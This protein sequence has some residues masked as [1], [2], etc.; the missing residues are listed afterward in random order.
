MN[1]NIDNEINRYYRKWL[2]I[3]INGNILHLRLPKNVL[4]YNIKTATEIHAQ[5]KLSVLII[6]TTSRNEETRNLHKVTNN[7]NVTYDY[8]LESTTATEKHQT[9]QISSKT[10]S[11]QT[12]DS[13]WTGFLN[14]NK[15]SVIIRSLV[16]HHPDKSLIN[17][18]N[19]TSTL[20]EN[21]KRFRRRYLIYILSNG[22]NLQK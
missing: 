3:L 18:Q 16:E 12:N 6:L 10:L 14:L 5:Y 20:L 22:K 19:V 8:T 4:G 9:K 21:I 2:Q 1:E 13:V 7:K 17:W 11:E 15:Q